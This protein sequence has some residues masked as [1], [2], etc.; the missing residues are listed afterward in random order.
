MA[1]IAELMGYGSVSYAR[2]RKFQCKEKLIALTKAAPLY[3]ELALGN[4]EAAQAGFER[5][6]AM[7]DNQSTVQPQWY[8]ALSWMKLKEPDNAKAYLL[9][10]SGYQKSA[11]DSLVALE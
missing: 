10:L 4:A 11:R 6:L 7:P 9:E 5:V 2:K 1:R 3:R 8:L